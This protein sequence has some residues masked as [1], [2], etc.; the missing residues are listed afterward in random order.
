MFLPCLLKF[1]SDLS[2]LFMSVT[3]F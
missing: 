1:L 2:F 3:H